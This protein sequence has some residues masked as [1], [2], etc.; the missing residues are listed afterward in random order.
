MWKKNAR[1]CA[2][3]MTG[4]QR[5]LHSNHSNGTSIHHIA[6]HRPFLSNNLLLHCPFVGNHINHLIFLN[7]PNP[8][9]GKNTLFPHT[10]RNKGNN[11]KKTQTH[12][13]KTSLSS[14]G[15]IFSKNKNSQRKTT[16]FHG[17]FRKTHKNTT[18]Q[19]NESISHLG[20]S[21][22]HRRKSTLR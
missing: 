2:C 8:I 11:N 17:L 4:R 5:P 18:L 16:D 7:R 14:R 6:F 3:T 22:N 20:K 15:F 10:H 12:K 19:G 9:W 13:K 21:K 1:S